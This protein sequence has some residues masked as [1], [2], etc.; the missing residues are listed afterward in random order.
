MRQHVNLFACS[1]ISQLEYE[2]RCGEQTPGHYKIVQ[3][4]A[5][6]RRY[7]ARARKEKYS[8]HWRFHAQRLASNDAVAMNENRTKAAN[9][10]LKSEK[11][12]VQSLQA[13]VEV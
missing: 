9:E 8:T 11:T 3:L 5:Y 7:L 2:E 4:Q 12:Y 10:I 1:S 6:V 13:V